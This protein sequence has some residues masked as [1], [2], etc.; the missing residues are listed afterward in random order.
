[1]RIIKKSKLAENRG[2]IVINRVDYDVSTKEG[3]TN[4][5][6]EIGVR[7]NNSFNGDLIISMRLPGTSAFMK[8]TFRRPIIALN[9]SSGN[10]V[11]TS[12]SSRDD[13]FLINLKGVI[14]HQV[15]NSI[16]NITTSDR[17]G[18]T[19]DFG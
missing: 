8:S 10:V 13:S 9:D 3:L 18:V 12:P 4:L 11:I 16:L 17:S 15:N 19:L 14:F 6:R 7:G 5:F 1:M 2:I